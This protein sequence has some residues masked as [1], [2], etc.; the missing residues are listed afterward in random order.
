MSLSMII[1][2]EMYQ[3]VS[4]SIAFSH[5][6]TIFSKPAV[7]I[8]FKE[9]HFASE[10]SLS[11]NTF[12]KKKLYSFLPNSFIFKLWSLMSLALKQYVILFILSIEPYTCYI[13]WYDNAQWV[14]IALIFQQ[15][16]YVYFCIPHIMSSFQLYLVVENV[17]LQFSYDKFAGL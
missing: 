4:K 13:T 15:Y 8:N 5:I 3:H 16:L 11:Y 10:I 7:I 1:N 2:D 6:D 14:Y 17:W 12:L 9:R